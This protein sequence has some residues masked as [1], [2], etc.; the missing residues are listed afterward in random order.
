MLLSLI[1]A[2]RVAF[3]SSRTYIG[4][5]NWLFACLGA[6]RAGVLLTLLLCVSYCDSNRC[7]LV[8]IIRV[9]YLQ[10]RL[11]YFWFPYVPESSTRLSLLTG[12]FL[13]GGSFFF[14]NKNRVWLPP[15]A[16]RFSPCVQFVPQRNTATYHMWGFYAGAFT[17]V[18]EYVYWPLILLCPTSRCQQRI[19]TLL[20]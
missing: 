11:G 9:Y 2:V 6:L 13:W 4:V 16:P 12:T 20:Q 8:R 15:R 14:Y 10:N 18:F 5:N 17:S 7:S 3:F 19:P 1:T